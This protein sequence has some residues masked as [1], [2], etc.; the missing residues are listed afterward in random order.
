MEKPIVSKV[1]GIENKPKRIKITSNFASLNNGQKCRKP[2]FMRV[3]GIYFT[4]WLYFGSIFG[5]ANNIDFS[6]ES[7]ISEYEI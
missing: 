3:S 2:V 4:K 7:D 6:V 1:Y 5:V